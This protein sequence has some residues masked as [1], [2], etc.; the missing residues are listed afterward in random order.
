[1]DQIS[2]RGSTGGVGV[3]A[4]LRISVEPFLALHACHTDWAFGVVPAQNFET[5]HERCDAF[6]DLLSKG[7][8]ALCE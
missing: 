7:Q 8:V 5:V 2:L 6:E 3:E 1:M 4:E